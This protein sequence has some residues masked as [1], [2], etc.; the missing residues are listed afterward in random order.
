MTPLLI[1]DV[2]NTL[3]ENGHSKIIEKAYQEALTEQD[4]L[5]NIFALS[6]GL[7]GLSKDTLHEKYLSRVTNITDMYELPLKY[8]GAVRVGLMTH[9]P[10]D[11]RMYKDK[12]ILCYVPEIEYDDAGLFV[13]LGGEIMEKGKI[14]LIKEMQTELDV[15]PEETAI[16]GDGLSE[17]FVKQSGAANYFIAYKPSDFLVGERADVIC[18]SGKEVEIAINHWLN[19]LQ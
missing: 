4:I 8:N 1:W 2:D 10:H 15:T 5:R 3:I 9:F 14:G 6:Q 12:G 7:V 16:V 17:A 19:S 11:L 13:G 18:N